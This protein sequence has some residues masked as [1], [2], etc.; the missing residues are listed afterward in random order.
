MAI[1]FGVATASLAAKDSFVAFKPKNFD[2]IADVA[3]DPQ[4]RYYALRLNMIDLFVRSDLVAPA[5]VPKSWSELTDAKYKGK[6]VIAD[7]SFTAVQVAV[8]ATL[9]LALAAGATLAEA[10]ALANQAAGIVVG[11]F[12]P[13]TLTAA[14]LVAS[15]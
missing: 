6:L 13:A 11:K 5:D 2:K 15:F 3:K 10:A 8:V 9:S 7:P 1:S 12:G 14:E 4:G